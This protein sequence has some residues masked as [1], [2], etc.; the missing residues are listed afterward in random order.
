MEI[1][2]EEELTFS[3]M[4]NHLGQVF[5]DIPDWRPAIIGI[6]LFLPIPI[7]LFFCTKLDLSLS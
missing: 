6:K 3:S 7:K 4:I 2:I 5:N 1:I